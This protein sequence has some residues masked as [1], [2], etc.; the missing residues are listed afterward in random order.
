MPGLSLPE[1][2][3]GSKAARGSGTTSDLGQNAGL[4]TP[5]P[6][7]GRRKTHHFDWRE[8]LEARGT[9]VRVR[10]VV[11]TAKQQFAAAFQS[12]A[13]QGLRE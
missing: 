10:T 5:S 6:L 3:G 8:V 7:T 9:A 13:K 12:S 1:P 2:G 11:K 4:S